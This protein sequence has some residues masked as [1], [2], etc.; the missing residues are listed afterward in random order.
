MFDIFVLNA[1]LQDASQVSLWLQRQN[2]V[3]LD[4]REVAYLQREVEKYIS[5]SDVYGRNQVNDS[6]LSFNKSGDQQRNVVSCNG[7]DSV[8]GIAIEDDALRWML[9]E[10]EQ[11]REKERLASEKSLSSYYVRYPG[12]NKFISNNESNE[13]PK[14][15]SDDWFHGV[16]I[17]STRSLG[18]VAGPSNFVPNSPYFSPERTLSSETSF[19]KS[20]GTTGFHSN[21]VFE[22][23][24]MKGNDDDKRIAQDFEQNADERL[25]NSQEKLKGR[26]YD[27]AESSSK[28]KEEISVN[29][30]DLDWVGKGQYF[31]FLTS[32][33][34]F[35]K[36]FRRVE[37]I[38][39][40][41]SISRL[42]FGDSGRTDKLTLVS[43]Q[44]ESKN[45]QQYNALQNAQTRTKDQGE[46]S[47]QIE[48]G[49]SGPSNDG[50]ATFTTVAVLS[51]AFIV[52]LKRRAIN[53]A[54]KRIRKN[55]KVGF[56]DLVAMGLMSRA[57]PFATDI[58]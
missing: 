21:S 3:A 40:T 34:L 29:E 38:A 51:V 43:N 7:F 46:H 17:S 39:S 12:Q 8:G 56:S 6:K 15:T 14:R 58:H 49:S 45:E 11:T 22:T 25:A 33:N 26:T 57:N 32:R 31:V 5:E 19:P 35:G 55:A 23:T 13:S 27:S 1:E 24:A 47:E 41:Q 42:I 52:Y 10:E 30:I 53:H 37:R 50:A 16:K 2:F 54:L 20:S 4:P 28:N 36:F 48:K 18:G 9:L 44:I